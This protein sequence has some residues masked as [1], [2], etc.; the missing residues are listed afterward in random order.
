MNVWKKLGKFYASSQRQTTIFL[1]SEEVEDLMNHLDW[2][3]SFGMSDGKLTVEK[4]FVNFRVY[5]V[6]NGNILS[7]LKEKA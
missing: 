3:D 6:L 2:F 4:R 1:T 5:G 7:L